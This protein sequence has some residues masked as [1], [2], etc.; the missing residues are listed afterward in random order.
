MDEMRAKTTHLPCELLYT[1]LSVRAKLKWAFFDS[2]TKDLPRLARE[3]ETL[4]PKALKILQ[5]VTAH[6]GKHVVYSSDEDFLSVFAAYMESQGWSHA[7]KPGRT[8]TSSPVYSNPKPPAFAMLPD[9]RMYGS[10]CSKRLRNTVKCAF[11]A[12]A[13]RHAGGGAR[14]AGDEKLPLCDQIAEERGERFPD[15]THGESVKVLLLSG[16]FKEGIS[17]L[18]V[19]AMHIVDPF[20]TETDQTQVLG[21]ALRYCSH[22]ATPWSA[23]LP[24]W[25]V[26]VYMYNVNVNE[27]P[28]FDAIQVKSTLRAE[29]MARAADHSL[30]AP[31]SARPIP[32]NARDVPE[33]AD[34]IGGFP[35][36]QILIAALAAGMQPPA[37]A[38]AQDCGRRCIPAIKSTLVQM[39]A[40][41]TRE[42]EQVRKNTRVYLAQM[43]AGRL[44]QFMTYHMA[45]ISR[46][47]HQWV[48]N[49]PP[50]MV[51]A[52]EEV[53]RQAGGSSAFG[54]DE[55]IPQSEFRDREE[56]LRFVNGNWMHLAWDTPPLAPTASQCSGPIRIHNSQRFVSEW[57]VPRSPWTGFLAFHSVG[58]GK[59]ILA[60]LVCRKF[61]QDPA[62]WRTLWVTRSSLKK[63]IEGDIAKMQAS[64]IIPEKVVDQVVGFKTLVNI[65]FKTQQNA[66]L[67]LGADALKKAPGAERLEKVLVVI[68]EAHLLFTENGLPKQEV[69]D[70]HLLDRL[71]QEIG[72]GAK[73]NPSRAR[74]LAMTATPDQDQTVWDGLRNL[75]GDHPC[76][77]VSFL[78]ISKDVTRFPQPVFKNASFSLPPDHALPTSLASACRGAS[79]PQIAGPPQGKA[80]KT[81]CIPPKVCNQVTGEALTECS[82]GEFRAPREL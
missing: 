15:N 27:R 74:V 61:V 31:M 47:K 17:L 76:G 57:F 51:S 21:R 75:C 23:S 60:L 73:D 80:C 36:T 53:M 30:T 71:I 56:M 20:L 42:H 45:K 14:K 33:R 25:R 69:P 77:N 2:A 79:G 4:A 78:D 9:S 6:A 50:Y 67:Y 72:S 24:G 40:R 49:L 5:N 55:Q 65:V 32:Y 34:H 43:K 26:D 44:Q 58:A 82:L 52:V 48:T 7:I 37:Q 64:G 46:V 28:L 3:I 22:T 38:P 1:N 10:D 11:N 68:D 12:S 70:R 54:A 16:R 81:P 8:K 66:N 41:R 18:N 39:I 19:A 13:P 35:L 62:R 59:T 29:I 63:E